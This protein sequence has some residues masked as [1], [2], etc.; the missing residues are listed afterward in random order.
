VSLKP[1][2]LVKWVRLEEIGACNEPCVVVRGPR[3]GYFEKP[4][5][6]EIKIVVDLFIDN[7]IVRGVPLEE[8]EKWK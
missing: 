8:V 2:D 5:W 1:G 6:N 4:P 7:R 3:E